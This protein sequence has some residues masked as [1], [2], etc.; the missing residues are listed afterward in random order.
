[1]DYSSL[2]DG[3]LGALVGAAIGAAAVLYQ[4]HRMLAAE[5]DNRKSDAEREIKSLAVAL[6]SELDDWYKFYIRDVL[7]R[8]RNASPSEGIRIK[9]AT[10]RAFVVFEANADKIGLFDPETAKAVVGYY[11]TARAFL[12]TLSDW[13][14]A[15]ERWESGEPTGRAKA[16]AL[17][18]QVRN[19]AELM[20]PVTRFAC[21]LLA[22][23]AGM[24]Y[25]FEE[26]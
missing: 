3:F 4:T 5:S 10:Y 26:P 13:G 6:L 17:F 18:P 25:T 19:A 8:M 21:Q 2:A 11:G 14:Q 23:R 9:S 1:M 15:H 16:A 22:D 24:A 20:V 12:N 7:R